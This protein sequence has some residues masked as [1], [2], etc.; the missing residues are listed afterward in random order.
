M[1]KFVATPSQSA[2]VITLS[3]APLG[4]HPSM[5][6]LTNTTPLHTHS[7]RRERMAKC[8]DHRAPGARIWITGK[9]DPPFHKVGP[10]KEEEKGEEEVG[11][12]RVSFRHRRM[13][14]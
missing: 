14:S 9:D 8:Y 1:C 5:T 11:G 12:R 3:C 4:P 10:V 6:T 2:V 13:K 7:Q